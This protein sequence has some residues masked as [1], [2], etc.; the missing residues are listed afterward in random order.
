VSTHHELM[1]LL[2]GLE[3]SVTELARSVNELELNLLHGTTTRLG[4]QRLKHSI[5]IVILPTSC[6][7]H[8]H[9]L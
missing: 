1:F 9:H 5:P 4:Q 3:A 8:K 7:S 2:V 6:I